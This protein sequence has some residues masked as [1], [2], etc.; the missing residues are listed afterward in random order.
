[1]GTTV[2]ASRFIHSILDAG[3]SQVV[4]ITISTDGRTWSET[5]YAPIPQNPVLTEA[6]IAVEELE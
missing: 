4:R 5:A 2:L 1:M 3:V 6:H